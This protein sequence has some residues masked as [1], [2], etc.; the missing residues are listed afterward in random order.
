MEPAAAARTRER[1]GWRWEGTTG[2]WRRRRL[3]G[4]EEKEVQEGIGGGGGA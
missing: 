4:L 3:R 1:E 2:D